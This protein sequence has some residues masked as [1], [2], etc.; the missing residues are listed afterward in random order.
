MCPIRH[1]NKGTFLS[2]PFS[3][4]VEMDR[5]YVRRL[6]ILHIASSEIWI[7]GDEYVGERELDPGGRT[8]AYGQ[9]SQLSLLSLPTLL[10]RITTYPN[11]IYPSGIGHIQ[12]PPNPNHFTIHIKFKARASI[13]SIISMKHK[14]KDPNAFL[15]STA[16]L[17]PKETIHSPEIET[18]E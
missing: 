17:T 1:V 14:F 16:K 6:F 13:T 3:A 4:S 18:T 2:I 12:V 11:P 10:T 7:L 15:L 8:R 5:K 9:E